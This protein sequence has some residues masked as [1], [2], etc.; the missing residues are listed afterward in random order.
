[1]VRIDYHTV[2]TM[3][4]IGEVRVATLW[5]SAIKAVRHVLLSIITAVHVEASTRVHSF[6]VGADGCPLEQLLI[7]E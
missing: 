3:E 2:L 6:L 1:M 5:H 4:A 7:E